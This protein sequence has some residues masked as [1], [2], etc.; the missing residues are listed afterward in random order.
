[1]STAYGLSPET[2]K[3][4]EESPVHDSGQGVTNSP[5]NWGIQSSVG[6]KLYDKMHTAAVYKIQQEQ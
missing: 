3:H 1:M 4:S 5:A 2:N 6:L